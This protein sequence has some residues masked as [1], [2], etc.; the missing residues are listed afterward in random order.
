[1]LTSPPA[2]ADTTTLTTDIVLTVSL[3]SIATDWIS[4]PGIASMHSSAFRAHTISST[5]EKDVPGFCSAPDA[6]R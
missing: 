5:A 4:I 3:L 1:V 6:V 2:H